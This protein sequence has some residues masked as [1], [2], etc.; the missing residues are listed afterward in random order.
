MIA[1]L[2]QKIEEVE[3]R[4][5]AKQLK[6]SNAI[7]HTLSAVRQIDK[8]LEGSPRRGRNPAPP[9]PGRSP[10]PPERVPRRPRR[11]AAQSPAFP[12]ALKKA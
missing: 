3:R 12:G 1:D 2:K 11:Q 8:A 6:E 9:R 4:A 5:A 10:G 7:K